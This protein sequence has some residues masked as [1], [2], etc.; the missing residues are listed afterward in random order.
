MKKL[1]IPLYIPTINNEVDYIS[2][3]KI[4]QDIE[5]CIILIGDYE[6]NKLSDYEYINVY[7]YLNTINS[8][9]EYYVEK[10]YND[11]LI[12][13]YQKKDNHIIT[14]LG[15]ILH[16]EINEYLLNQKLNDNDKSLNK[17]LKIFKDAIEK[18]EIQNII[19][20]LLKKKKINYY[21]NKEIDNLLGVYEI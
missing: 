2:L 1:V 9:N 18:N 15:N 10:E 21:E 17:Y 3:E 4:I 16:L 14:K 20:I 5:N 19:Y 13:K 7:L 6:F 12:K 11:K 8:K